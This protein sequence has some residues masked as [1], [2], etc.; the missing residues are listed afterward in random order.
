LDDSWGLAPALADSIQ[1]L[2]QQG[3]ASFVPFAGTHDTTRSHFETQDHIELGQPDNASR[4][5]RSGFMNRLAGVL[6]A[7]ASL[8]AMAF[9]DQV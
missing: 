3:Q 6:G 8:E 5:F 1:P 4:D 2:W 9:T 7:G